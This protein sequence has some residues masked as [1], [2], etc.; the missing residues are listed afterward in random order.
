MSTLNERDVGA[1]RRVDDEL[2]EHFTFDAG[3]TE[4]VRDTAA[5]VNP[6]ACMTGFSTWN[7][8]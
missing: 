5:S 7:S 3:L 2:R 1:A 8:K 6:G 4:N